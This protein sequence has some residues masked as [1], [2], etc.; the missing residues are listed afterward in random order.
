[1][2]MENGEMRRFT[3]AKDYLRSLLK[4]DHYFRISL[5]LFW[6]LFIVVLE[7]WVY[8]SHTFSGIFSVMLV[9]I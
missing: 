2:L 3:L 6:Q 1:M 7:K 5:G 4:E 9:V 8:F